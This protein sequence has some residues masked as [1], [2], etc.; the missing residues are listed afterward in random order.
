MIHLARQAH[1]VPPSLV[2]VSRMKNFSIRRGPEGGFGITFRGNRPVFIRSVDFNSPAHSAGLRS[3]DLI[4]TM[5]GKNVR[6]AA[7]FTK[8]V[9]GKENLGVLS[10]GG[11]NHIIISHALPQIFYKN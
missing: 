8:K 5:D 2:V 3:G 11:K 4:M 10:R 1:K 6:L 9:G 7:K